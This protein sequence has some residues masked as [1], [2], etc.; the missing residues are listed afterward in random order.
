MTPR[1]V[2]TIVL[3]VAATVVFAGSSSAQVLSP[4]TDA[5]ELTL[6]EAVRRAVDN[7]PDL[8]IVRL[9]TEIGAAQVAESQSAFVPVFSTVAAR[10]SVVTPASNLLAGDRT[11]I[12][13]DDWFSSTGVRQRL[14]W[15]SGTWGVTWDASRTATDSLFS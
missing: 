11:R 12:S 14:P 5:I 4:R 2:G 13:V 7:N 1:L 10:S 3:T 6:E 9:D 15:G 8:A